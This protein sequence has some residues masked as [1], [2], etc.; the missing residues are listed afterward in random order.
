MNRDYFKN[1]VNTITTGLSG[2]RSHF[3]TRPK[4]ITKLDSEYACAH[5]DTYYGLADKTLGSD[6]LWNILADINLPCYP[7]ELV[8]EMKINLP[9][10]VIENETSATIL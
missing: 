6:K 9:L 7:T 5:G 10:V 3:S 2:G 4:F 8:S 1:K